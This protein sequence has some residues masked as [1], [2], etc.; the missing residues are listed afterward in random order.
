MGIMVYSL[1]CIMQALYHKP[2]LGYYIRVT[3][4]SEAFQFVS[5]D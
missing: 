2:C 4:F 5:R 3:Y 1:L